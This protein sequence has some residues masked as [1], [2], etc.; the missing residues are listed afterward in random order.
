MLKVILSLIFLVCI[1]EAKGKVF[2]KCELAKE[3]MEVHNATVESA[4]R[5]VCGA[6]YSSGF[7]TQFYQP[8]AYGIFN[9]SCGIDET[10]ESCNVP[11]FMFNDDVI[12]DD[13]LCAHDNPNPWFD[14]LCGN[15]TTFSLDDC[16][17]E[18]L[19]KE[20]KAPT[21][22]PKVI[23]E[24]SPTPP[25]MSRN[26]PQNMQHHKLLNDISIENEEGHTIAVNQ[27]E[28]VHIIHNLVHKN[29]KQNVRYIFL[30]V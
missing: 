30:F 19:N 12:E 22:A 1:H 29:R 25:L 6:Q 10:F 11:C 14:E 15:D 7:D 8:G 13:Y 3:L 4:K 27:L 18:S 16:A 23:P 2:E 17:L 24:N 9:V 21:E 28:R 20:Q 26:I 5:L